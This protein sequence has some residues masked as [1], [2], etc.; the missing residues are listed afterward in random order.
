MQRLMQSLAEE[1]DR[2]SE[3]IVTGHIF[4][5]TQHKFKIEAQSI[6]MHLLGTFYNG[7]SHILDELE[8]LHAST[9]K[10]ATS[11]IPDS[12]NIRE[13]VG[14][15]ITILERVDK[16]CIF[17][18]ALDECTDK[19][20]LHEVLLA[21]EE[22]QAKTGV[23]LVMTDRSG[24]SPLWR[25]VYQGNENCV[26]RKIEADKL[27]IEA[28]IRSSFRKRFNTDPDTVTKAVNVITHASDGM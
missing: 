25:K 12:P 3:E 13:I 22:V 23:G 16:A 2:E 11:M 7:A 20:Q 8:Q 19:D 17:I 1:P 10:A 9:P 26:V 27:D 4:F 18:D 21:I 28:F 14:T 6:L 5:S 24:G 15:L